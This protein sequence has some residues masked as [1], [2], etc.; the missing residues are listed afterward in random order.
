LFVKKLVPSIYCPPHNPLWKTKI[1][2]SNEDIWWAKQGEGPLDLLLVKQVLGD[3]TLC[4]T[5][6]F[7]AA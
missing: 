6:Y 4:A 5:D 2:F 1:W 7:R 3:I